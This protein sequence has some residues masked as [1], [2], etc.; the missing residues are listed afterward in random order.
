MPRLFF[1]LF[2]TLLNI[3]ANPVLA[4]SAQEE[5]L[6]RNIAV[7][8]FDNEKYKELTENIDFTEQ[9]I[10][11][12]KKNEKQIDPQTFQ[13]IGAFLKFFF[14][15]LGIGILV[16]LL[17]KALNNEDLFSPRNK[18]IKPATQID[19]EKIED[20]LE[21]A[22]LNGPIQQA[23]AAGDYPLAVRLYYLAVLKDLSLSKKIN[24][25]KD[26]TNGE[27][28]RELAGTPIFKNMQEITLVFERIWYGK[29]ALNK[30]DFLGIEQLFL[31]MLPAKS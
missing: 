11:P 13:G 1:I 31:K 20:N 23:I 21:G 17:I 25:K 2:F 22:E 10:Q 9:E 12:K 18:K 30:E 16:F 4:Q 28:L 7:H 26:K 19:L 27:Y 24:W 6:Q 14:I 29:M 5:Y 8:R 3:I 15:A